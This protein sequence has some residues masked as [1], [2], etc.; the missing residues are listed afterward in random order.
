MKGDYIMWHGALLLMAIGS[1][2]GQCRTES[3]DRTDD[4]TEALLVL[5]NDE[6]PARPSRARRKLG[7]VASLTLPGDLERLG[8]LVN[9]LTAAGVEYPLNDHWKVNVGA[10]YQ[11]LSNG[12]Q[13]DPNPSLNLLGPQVGVTYNF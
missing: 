12:G 11:H 13:T 6:D 4:K 10:L 7:V 5:L 8:G 1:T 2:S 9:I 3:V